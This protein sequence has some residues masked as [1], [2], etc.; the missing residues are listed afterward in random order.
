MPNL[1]W[2]RGKGEP[3]QPEQP[4]QQPATFKVKVSVPRAVIENSAA[5]DLFVKTYWRAMLEQAGGGFE[6]RVL[7]LTW[8]VD[9][10]YDENWAV[11][12]EEDSWRMAAVVITGLAYLRLPG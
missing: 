12:R 10:F 7:E 2:L 4:K 1:P 8:A 3:K 6:P 5:I 11:C 9:A